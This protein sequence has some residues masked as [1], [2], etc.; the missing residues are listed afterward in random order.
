[1]FTSLRSTEISV[2]VA[3]V[4]IT[5]FPANAGCD[6]ATDNQTHIPENRGE[7]VKRQSRAS[8]FFGQDSPVSCAGSLLTNILVVYP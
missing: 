4:E 5:E 1:M 7:T 2:H 6:C 8:L 3:C